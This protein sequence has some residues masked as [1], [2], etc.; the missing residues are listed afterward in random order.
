LWPL[1]FQPVWITEVSFCEHSALQS[2]YGWYTAHL[3]RTGYPDPL[4]WGARRWRSLMG[5][6]KMIISKEV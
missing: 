5:Q 2:W 3:W 4:T 6:V 1:M